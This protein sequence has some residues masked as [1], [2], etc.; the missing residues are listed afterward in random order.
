MASRIEPASGGWS[1]DDSR[2][3]QDY[4]RI[5]V[6]ERETQVAIITDLIATPSDGAWLVDLC[7]G[8]GLLTEALLAR[9]PKARVLALDGSDSM[10]AR[11]RERALGHQERLETRVIDLAKGDWRNFDAYNQRLDPYRVHLA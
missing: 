6:P 10:L 1:E 11:T 4:G 7:C 3:F 9:F 5:F 2:L 8:A